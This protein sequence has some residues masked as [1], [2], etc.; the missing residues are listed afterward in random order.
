MGYFI[1]ADDYKHGVLLAKTHW[2]GVK[3]GHTRVYLNINLRNEGCD[4]KIFVPHRNIVE[5]LL[6][7]QIH[8]TWLDIR[9]FVFLTGMGCLE[10]VTF[11]LCLPC[12]VYGQIVVRLARNFDLEG[13]IAAKVRNIAH[14]RVHRILNAA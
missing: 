13:E 7:V 1:F 2:A 11:A 3:L 14:L 4:R 5:K 6:P 12:L 10:T 8:Q 9:D